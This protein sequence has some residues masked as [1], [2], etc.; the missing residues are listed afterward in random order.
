MLSVRSGFVLDYRHFRDKLVVFVTQFLCRVRKASLVARLSFW[1]TWYHRAPV[2]FT[3][4]HGLH[5]LRY[6]FLLSFDVHHTWSATASQE[7]KDFMR[8]GCLLECSNLLPGCDVMRANQGI[9]EASHCS[10]YNGTCLLC[11]CVV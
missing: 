3:Y 6:I 5:P 7:C 10:F 8:A 1:A 9:M 2:E 4:L 11:A